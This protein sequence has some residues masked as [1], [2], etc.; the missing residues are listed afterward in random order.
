MA[1]PQGSVTPGQTMS[2]TVE[3]ENVGS[4][5]ALGV[6]LKDV[7]DPSLDD[8]S[9]SVRDMYS[10][11]FSSGVAI[12]TTPANFPW[13]YDPQ[14]RTFTLLAGNANASAGGSF[15]LETK[16]KSTVPPGTVIP[17]QGFVYFPNA[18]QQVTPT[19]TVISAVPLATS[20]ASVGASS[21]V[22]L[23][24]A[25]LAAQLTTSSGPAQNQPVSFQ[26]TD[27]SSAAL[28][29]ASGTASVSTFLSTGAGTYNLSLNYP[30]DHFYYLPTSAN[31]SFTVAPRGVKL[32]APFA[33]VRPTDTVHIVLTMTDDGGQPL[34]HQAD[35]PKT[36]TLEQLDPNGIPT[37]LASSLLSGTT[38]EFSFAVPQPLQ[39]S[40]PLRARFDGDARYAAASSTGTLN[41]IDDIAPTLSLTS[42]QGGGVITGAGQVTVNY[43][44]TDNTDLS[45]SA[46]AYLVSLSGG[47]LQTVPNGGS[48]PASSLAQG[49][50][51]VIVSAL[52]WA[53]NTSTASSGGFLVT[54]DV[55]P[56]QTS[57][58]VGT[59]SY[60]T[61]PVFVSSETWLSLSV[62]DD[63]SVVGDGAGIGVAQ[64]FYAVDGG[65]YTVYAAPFVLSGEGTHQVSFYSVDLAGNA[66]TP[67]TRNFFIDTT[68]PQ[69]QLLLG[70]VAVAGSSAVAVSSDAV[71]F[72]TA[73]AGSG[74]AQT[75]YALDAST[76]PVPAAAPFLLQVGTH[77]LSY[78]SV[79]NLGNAE[80]ARDAFL[81]VLAVDTAPPSVAVQPPDGSTVTTPAPA[82]TAEY[83]DVG[84]G[85]DAASVRLE[86]DGLDVTSSATVTASSASFVPSAA[87][88]QATH[89]FVARASDLAGNASSATAVFLVD[90]VPPVTTLLVQRLPAGTTDLVIVSTDSLGFAASDAGTGVALT[91][92]ALDGGTQTVFVSTFSLAVGT[93]TLAYF[94]T[95]GAGNAE[96]PRAAFLTVKSTQTDLLPPLLSL[97]YPSPAAR[98]V[99]RAIGAIVSVRG[100]VY[101]DHILSWTLSVAPGVAAST[102]YATLASGTTDAAGVLTSWDTG[103]LAGDYTLRLAA[104]DAF[105]NASVS[106]AAVFVGDPVVGFSMGRRGANALVPTLKDPQGIAVRADGL[107]WVSV[108][109]DARL[110]LLTSSG[111]VVTTVGAG[112]GDGDEHGHGHG[113]ED[114][115]GRDSW[116]LILKHPRGLS[117]DATGNLFVADR[118]QDRVVELS[119]DGSQVLAEFSQGLSKPEDAVVDAD[120]TVFV[121]DTGNKRVRVFAPDGSVRR[122]IPTASGHGDSRPWGLAL[123]SRGLWVSDR[124]RGEIF[125]FTRD[126]VLLKTIAGAGRVTGAAAD[127]PG[128]LYAADRGAD[129][130]RKYD[131]DGAPLLAFGSRRDADRA[132]RHSARFL[133]DPADAAVAPDGSLWVA[134][135]GHDR[136]VRFVLPD[137]APSHGYGVASASG[138]DSADDLKA[139]AARTVDPEDGGKV[140][141]DDGSKVSVPPGALTSALELSVQSAPSKDEDAKRLKR[142][143]EK[144]QPASEEVEYGPE[145]TRF[146]TPVTIT[147]PYDAAQLALA[148]LT[149]EQLRVEYWNPTTGDWEPLASTVDKVAGTVSAQTSHFSVY[150]VMGTGG[151]GVAATADQTFAFHAAYAFPNPV[152]GTNAVTIR[153]QPGL[154][155]S[156]EVRVY[157]LSGRKIHSSSDFKVNLALDDGNGLGPQVTYDHVWDISG[158]GSGVYTYVITARK[159]GHP[160]IH[161]TGR[162]GVIK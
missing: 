93:H 16:L 117:L 7:L 77:T 46:T 159:A 148:G 20:L 106:T 123:T 101:D 90:S 158:V 116:T 145:G 83:S 143:A 25:G 81:T 56:P 105:G 103:A 118:D 131:P 26:L 29:D 156:V 85:I 151:T 126:G 18:L 86:L 132:E 53:G 31:A 41:L 35:A 157:D 67:Q 122:D 45:P 9:L 99:E 23:S 63:Q 124:A 137:Q 149:P 60:G 24:T 19:N 4:G 58:S 76:T 42:P 112:R 32:Q 21:G 44:V 97:D 91:D 127:R 70:G 108:D 62:I 66:E 135:S 121:A 30:G 10:L 43:T 82:L 142:L 2:Y 12:S 14:T 139:P 73:D 129:L 50:W 57:L 152:R 146:Q 136:V 75:L 54:S 27:F 48:M 89:T 110:L 74:V 133:S 120:G 150:Q 15:V 51:T 38:V 102:G 65:S 47:Q 13:S 68:A 94:S 72:S 113:R 125:L 17:N 33:A 130:I 36:V 155:D 8:T 52:D 104:L 64:S 55:L 11:V 147:I 1:G 84:R 107:I 153:I 78:W 109:A 98:G 6:Y 92:Y 61:N 162:V 39:L 128:A 80:A 160:D 140:A 95:D 22:Y 134:D 71:S 69:T 114:E 100:S 40:W 111:S 141:R 88:S 3:F 138:G 28:T 161:K 87:L 154:A 59:P 5:T 119:P 144:V 115:H 49:S 79:D 37:T 34:L 96:S